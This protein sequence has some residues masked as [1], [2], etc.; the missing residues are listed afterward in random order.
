MELIA[1][2]DLYV[3]ALGRRVEK[4]DRVA[5]D[6]QVG[7]SLHAQGWRRAPSK[8]KKTEAASDITEG[9]E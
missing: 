3:P 4:G 5:V 8:S 9:D 7:E 6:G 2:A 1:P